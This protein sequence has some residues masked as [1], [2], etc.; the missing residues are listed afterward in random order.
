LNAA[1]ATRPEHVI[2]VA[3]TRRRVI[4][5][6]GRLPWHL[7]EDLRLFRE[8]TTGQAVVMGRRT[9]ESI[10]RPLPGRRNL[11]VSRTLSPRQGIEVCRSFDEALARTAG[12]PGRVFFIGGAEIYALAL[13]V[14]DRLIVTWVEQAVEGDV[15]F[16]A[17]D[18]SAWTVERSEPGAGF[19]RVWYRRACPA[20]L[21]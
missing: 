15:H 3:M 6:S 9:F 8:L 2:V 4:G 1:G 11:V 10:G 7:P 19:V 18:E 16:P 20:T 14:A 5:A 13:P 17:F 12:F 21:T